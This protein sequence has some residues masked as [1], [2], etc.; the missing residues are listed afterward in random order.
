MH[1]L[2]EELL[3]YQ[4]TLISEERTG[5]FTCKR[6]L[7]DPALEELKCSDYQTI[8]ELF[9]SKTSIMIFDDKKILKIVK[10]FFSKRDIK[11]L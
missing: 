9:R 2:F 10:D 8:P 4:E 5:L 6:L 11:Q 7:S 1:I 3:V